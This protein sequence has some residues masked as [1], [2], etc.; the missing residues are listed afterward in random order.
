MKTVLPDHQQSLVQLVSQATGINTFGV[1]VR[2]RG[3]DLHIL[4]EG[5]ECPQR[6]RTLSDLLRVLQ[7][8][9]LDTLTSSEQP[10]I[11]QVFVYGRKK[12]QQR[13]QWCHRVYLNQIERHLEQVQ[14]ALLEDSEKSRQPGGALIV[15]NES[16]ARQ[17][18]PDAI[19]RY[20]SE[21]LSTLGV[22]VQVKIRKSQPRQNS[23]PDENRLWI[24]C[25]SSYSPDAS[26][27]AEPVAQKLRHL[28]LSGYQD[29]VI[30][31]Q[32]SGES[33]PDWLLR[34]DLTPPEM[35]LKEWARW[36]D[37]QAIA[38]LLTELFA[39]S[40]VAIQASLKESTLHIF[41]TPAFDPLETAPAPDKAKCLEAILPLIEAIA[42]QGILAATIYGQKTGDKQPAWIDWVSL[43]ATEHPALAVSA[44]EL[45]TS[46]DEP[47]IVFL[48]ERLLNPDLEWR[49]LT[50][51]IRVLLLN[52]G[53]LLHIMCDAPVCPAR[54]KV[55]NKVA[56]F[57]RQLKLTNIMGVRVYGRR[58]G[59]KEPFWHYGVDF[60]HRQRLVPEAT[61]EF[62]ATSQYVSDLITSETD[63]PV[64]R[65]DL[66][67]EEV[68]SFVTGV[69]RDWVTTASATAKKWLLATQLFTESNQS[70]N[71]NS[72]SQG[73]KVALVW[74]TLG[75]LLTLQTDWVLGQIIARTMQTPTATSVSSASS[76]K[77]KASLTAGKNQSESERTAFLA[78]TS[79]TKSPPNN[80]SVFNASEFTES[81]DTQE[82]N[83]AAAPLK[84]KATATAILLAA[85]SQMPSFNVRQL[86]EQLVLYKQRLAKTGN[87]PDVLIIGSSRALRGVDP[88]A[89]SKALATQGYPNLD[90]FNFGINGATAQVV[91]F[92]IR[93]VL[94]PSELPKLIVWADGA[95]AFNSGREDMTFKSI[96]A[97]NGYKQALQKKL[98]T[99]NSDQALKNPTEEQKTKAEKQ[100]ISIYQAVDGWL[101]QGLA[102]FSAS[103][104]NRDQ[105]KSLLQKQFTS[106]PLVS[107]RPQTIASQTQ[108][109]T[110]N[111]EEYTSQ[112]A[113]DFDGFLPLSIRFNPTRYY[114]KHS[115]VPGNYD[116]DYKSF[117]IGGEQDAAFK[118]VLQFTQ[119]KKISL[120]FV[121]TPLTAD[122]LDPVRKKYEQEFQQFMLSLATSPN[123]IYRDLSQQWTKTN[124]Y[125]SDPSHLNRFGAYEVSKK[126]AHD[127]MIPWPTK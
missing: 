72:D 45:A 126:L 110:D 18:H 39:E 14:Q 76:S 52:K 87:P 29:A 57:V 38:L 85:R 119:S 62:A 98:A 58:A 60:D 5:T 7:Q 114:Q 93:E 105:I 46:G 2:L 95:R 67:T 21:T 61:P 15:S 65:P 118:A 69:A 86:D 108:S 23:Q 8:T 9:D 42:P 59:N 26:L 36:G 117:Q 6:W 1:K 37:V 33:A 64:L 71:L 55:A 4:C 63:E 90:V 54:K 80:S 68:Q 112:Q 16:L 127:P 25:Q 31:S 111:S 48:L 41:C 22:A 11:Y 70:E 109:K 12:E 19:A 56:Q 49:L 81:D 51:G 121:N 97:S 17:G 89:L 88:A 13:P 123:F 78:N 107:D 66:T 124:D 73:L 115:R 40:K 92:V 27:L 106:L 101:N 10:S 74:G 94:E 116:N 91:D 79:K 32:V 44:L 120:V 35:M 84:E 99:P 113:V 102:V 77:Q 75:L 83:L 20:L 122:Y 3:N 96:A 100:E 125:F 53:D 82:R 103:Y 28:K 24:F 34:I 47:A 104:Q 50:G 30:V 43:P